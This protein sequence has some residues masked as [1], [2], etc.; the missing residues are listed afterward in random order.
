MYKGRLAQG[1]DAVAVKRC[2]D[3]CEMGLPTHYIR[4]VNALFTVR[5]PHLLHGLCFDAR[6]AW[7][8]M[9]LK[10]SDLTAASSTIGATCGFL[11]MCT[12]LSNGLSA[13]HSAGI[14]HRDIKP[15]NILYDCDRH[16]F[17]LSDFGSAVPLRPDDVAIWSQPEH[18]GLHSLNKFSVCT[19]QVCTLWFSAPEVVCGSTINSHAADVWSLG[20]SLCDAVLGIPATTSVFAAPSGKGVHVNQVRLMSAE[21]PCMAAYGPPADLLTDD[22]MLT[23]FSRLGEHLR[24][25]DSIIDSPAAD[26]RL[27]N[28][29]QPYLLRLRWHV[30]QPPCVAIHMMD[31]S[32]ISHTS[33]P[34]IRYGLLLSLARVVGL[35]V[36]R[37]LTR[38]LHLDP[39]ARL[40]ALRAARAFSIAAVV[41]TAR[42]VQSGGARGQVLCCMCVRE[43]QVFLQSELCSSGCVCCGVALGPMGV[44]AT[45]RLCSQASRGP[46]VLKSF[47][48]RLAHEKMPCEVPAEGAPFAWPDKI[49]IRRYGRDGGV[50]PTDD[51]E[52]RRL[53][54][55]EARRGLHVLRMCA[56]ATEMDIFDDLVRRAMPRLR[57]DADAIAHHVKA[58]LSITLK[59]CRGLVRSCGIIARLF[60]AGDWLEV[61]HTEASILEAAGGCVAHVFRP[62]LPCAH[63][64]DVMYGLNGVPL[65]MDKF[66]ERYLWELLRDASCECVH[67]DDARVIAHA[68]GRL[69]S[70]YSEKQ[71]A[72]A[73]GVSVART[74]DEI[75]G[76]MQAGEDGASCAS[77]AARVSGVMNPGA[78]VTKWYLS[79]TNRDRVH[80]V[81]AVLT[82]LRGGESG[83]EPRCGSAAAG[84]LASG[85]CSGSIASI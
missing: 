38:M 21:A 43:K 56:S 3:R 6:Q 11:P 37:V 44:D 74:L 24:V 12:Q 60:P 42:V 19:Q 71:R 23:T 36:A 29:A 34:C 13:L 31:V 57:V 47:I 16:L 8:A 77:L 9:P 33:P 46:S 83:S 52:Y 22:F 53:V 65:A 64:F 30:L 2:N 49:E 54:H 80:F 70:A 69:A 20:V 48:D 27:L 63:S 39:R 66:C 14:A 1:G 35:L 7:I 61:M 17:C 51:L 10:H 73:S 28:I 76:E 18:A 45:S 68:S 85:G 67:R 5:S 59:L 25:V 72:E 79:V 78:S 58:C 32:S 26:L 84:L 82:R 55:D 40:T 15:A 41:H 4:E 75:A 50:P 62:R 81:I